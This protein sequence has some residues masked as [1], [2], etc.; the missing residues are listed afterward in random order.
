MQ[1]A[2]YYLHIEPGNSFV[3]GGMYMP[4]PSLLF[5]VRSTIAK[6]HITFK[7]II[8][9]PA[10][11]KLYGELCDDTLKTAP[12]GFPKDH[13]AVE[14][15]RHKHFYVMSSVE[16]RELLG[17]DFL[18]QCVKAFKVASPFVMFLNEAPV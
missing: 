17:K 6:N 8:S 15:L 3:S 5:A 12:K 11:K 16:D 2:G 13:P 7:R 9:A 18:K 4:G 1:G 10:F 14:F